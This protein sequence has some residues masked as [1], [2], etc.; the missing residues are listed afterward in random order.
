MWVLLAV[1]CRGFVAP[2]L[3]RTHAPTRDGV[4]PVDGAFLVPANAAEAVFLLPA[5]GPVGAVAAPKGPAR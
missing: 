3:H 2:F 4:A 5:A 1:S